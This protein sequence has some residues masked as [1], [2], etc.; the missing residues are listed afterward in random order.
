MDSGLGRMQIMKEI[1]NAYSE[2]IGLGMDQRK[3][4]KIYVC[5]WLWEEERE[6][7]GKRGSGKTSTQHDPQNCN[8]SQY[9]KRKA[10]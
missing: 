7:E 10:K 8:N 9:N 2:R 4:N 6:I 1:I 3:E 5:M